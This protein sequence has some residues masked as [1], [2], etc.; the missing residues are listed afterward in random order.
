VTPLSFHRSLYPRA[1]VDAAVAAYTGFAT[2]DVQE[3]DPLTLVTLSDLDPDFAEFP[4]ELCDAFANHALFEA[5]R[6]RRAG[7]PA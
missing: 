7:S 5:I 4:E 1:A 2:F 3:Q 6:A